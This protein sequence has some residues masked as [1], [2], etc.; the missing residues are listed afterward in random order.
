RGWL[1]TGTRLVSNRAGSSNP[2]ARIWSRALGREHATVIERVSGHPSR[3]RMLTRLL[4]QTWRESWKLLLA[5]FGVAVVLFAGTAAALGL[6]RAFSS[7]VSSFVMACAILFVPALYGAMAFY[8]DQ[9][10]GNYRFL[11]EH[12]ARP[13]YIWLARQ[14][15]WLGA[16]V[17]VGLA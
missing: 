4:W 13:R 3:R 11:A 7:D 15:V 16:L 6:T 10:R 1:T 14:I 9:R 8:C 5:P 12:A 2:F 17:M